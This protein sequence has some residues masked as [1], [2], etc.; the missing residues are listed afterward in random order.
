MTAQ[1]FMQVHALTLRSNKL[2]D[3]DLPVSAF[4]LLAVPSTPAAV[5]EAVIEKSEEGS[6]AGL[7]ERLDRTA[8]A[9]VAA[10]RSTPDRDVRGSVVMPLPAIR[11]AKG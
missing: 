9:G 4:Y 11:A 8:V 2:L 10:I 6:K 1:R 7:V 5:V 3:L